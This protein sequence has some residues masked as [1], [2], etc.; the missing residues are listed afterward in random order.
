M[1]LPLPIEAYFEANSRLEAD[2]ML[3]PFA[4]DALVRDDG[5]THRGS[6][7]IAD[8]I[9]EA[10]LAFQA[11]AEPR[12]SRVEDGAHVVTAE[13]S[14]GFPGSPLALPFRF[15]LSG[16]RIAELEIG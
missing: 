8:W 6:A 10:S 3:A 2:A 7:A 15:R 13:V 14:G 5:H 9:G 1:N 4:P 16:G 12:S 11:V